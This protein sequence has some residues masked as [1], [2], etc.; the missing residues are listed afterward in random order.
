MLYTSQDTQF[1]GQ[2]SDG[3]VEMKKVIR[4]IRID[5]SSGKTSPP[6]PIKVFYSDSDV[7]IE[8]QE[9]MKKGRKKFDTDGVYAIGT[10]QEEAWELFKKLLSQRIKNQDPEKIYII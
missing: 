4:E 9:P 1:K 5:Y 3:K 8:L 2:M 7:E 10:T 6:I